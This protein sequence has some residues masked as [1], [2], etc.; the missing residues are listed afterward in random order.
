MARDNSVML[1]GRLGKDP[2]IRELKNTTLVNFRL[3]VTRPPRKDGEDAGTDWLS[4]SAFGYLAEDL[5]VWIEEGKIAK[6]TRVLVRGSIQVTEKETDEGGTRT[7]TNIVLDDVAIPA[8]FASRKGEK[9]ARGGRA[10]Q[11]SAASDDEFD[12]ESF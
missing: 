8:Q 11:A 7:F 12:V 2:D 3:A 5:C 6:G 1:V 4:C 10:T 9:G